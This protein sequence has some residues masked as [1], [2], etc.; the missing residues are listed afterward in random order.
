MKQILIPTDFSANAWNTILYAMELYKNIPCEFHILN[1]YEVK[2]V[3]L[4]GTVSS[5]RVG[6]YYD[7]IKIESGEGLEMILDDI[8]NSGPDPK[9]VFKTYS[10]S[11]SLIEI[12]REMTTDN[13]FDQ[14]IIGTKGATGAKEIF[15]GSNTHRIIKNIHSCPILV[16]PDDVFFEDISNIA[17][18]TNFER[19][20]YRSEIT[21]ILELAKYQ[22]A[23]VRMIHVYDKPGLDIVQTYNSTS[24]ER[25]FKGVKHDF[26]VIHDFSNIEKAIESFVE[27]LE[28]NVLAMINYEHSFIERITREAI[29]KKITFRTTI[30]FLVIPAD[31]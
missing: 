2:P 9:H 11:G 20:Y 4:I 15:L 13:H 31:N 28:I 8:N 12:V 17:F 30:P 24:L 1:T 6:H 23:S 5:Q 14:I 10:K 19:I 26:H 22:D 18:A 27:E 3:Q 25:Y 16:V 21:P 7:A 29:I